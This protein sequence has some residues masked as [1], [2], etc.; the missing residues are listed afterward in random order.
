MNEQRNGRRNGRRRRQG[1]VYVYRTHATPG[2]RAIASELGARITRRRDSRFRADSAA[3]IINWGS[4]NAPDL[5][6]VINSSRSVLTAVDKELLRGLLSATEGVRVPKRLDLMQA[7]QKLLDGKRIVARSLLRASGGRGMAV[8]HPG[9]HIPERVDGVP[10]KAYYEYI[11]K[12]KEYRVH[13]ASGYGIFHI[14]QKRRRQTVDGGGDVYD[15]EIRNAGNGWVYCHN[16]IQEIPSEV[17]HQGWA[18]F[19][20]SGLDFGAVDVIYMQRRNRAWVLEIN[21]APG[22]EGATVQKYGEMLRF[23]LNEKYGINAQPMR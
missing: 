11:P 15:N 19:E 7:Q 12:S 23:L 22:L 21:T 9:E 18:G 10:V 20:A 16:E 3:A 1:G 13:C 17:L 2:G 14:Q 5:P 4:T 8:V 6:T